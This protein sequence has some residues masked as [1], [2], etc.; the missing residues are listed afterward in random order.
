M[1]VALT[2]VLATGAVG[3]DSGD[4]NDGFTDQEWRLIHEMSMNPAVNPMPSNPVNTQADDP[5]VIKLGQ[6]LMFETEYAEAITVDNANGKKGETGKVGC[7][8]CHDPKFYFVRPEAATPGL[9]ATGRRNVP[10]MLNVGYLQWFGWTGR[11]D[12]LVMHG[13][14]VMGTAAT[15][16]AVMH[17]IY[18]KYR[19]QWE[20][21]FPDHPLDPALDPMA[22]DA[23]RFPPTGNPKANETA[24]DGN[25]EKMTADDQHKMD[26]W[27]WDVGCIWEAYPRA[28]VTRNSAFQ[29]WIDGDKTA[30][31]PEA[32][33]GL[34]LFLGKAACSDCH[35]GPAL[36]DSKAHNVA[37]PNPPA[38]PPPAMAPAPDMGRFADLAGTLTHKFNGI[39]EFS[40]NKA[41]GQ[42]KL[43]SAPKTGDMSMQG[44][45]KTMILLNVEKTGPYFH[46]GLTTTL[47]DVVQH[48]NKGGAD[49]GTFTGV[50]DTR[51]KPLNLT[52]M[53]V[54]DIVAFLKSLTGTVPEDLVRDIRPATPPA[55]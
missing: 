34:K 33:R 16:L 28:M 4:S 27:A 38:P 52:E 49:P 55:P 15:R 37:V 31:S 44:A 21:A 50:K 25:W 10:N 41:F 29:Q 8:T 6:M 7:I 19:T 11:H 18:K 2:A 46:T 36:S 3:C 22:A 5:N 26:Q 39:S 14:G 13:S 32:K 24:P 17:Y 9:G 42:M 12:S 43:D 20:A 40:D 35:S 47:E 1:G 48:Y 23:A 54:A 51:L 45:F 53:E 30:L